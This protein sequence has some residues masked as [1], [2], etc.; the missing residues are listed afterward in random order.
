[1]LISNWGELRAYDAIPAEGPVSD[2]VARE[3]IHGYY[4]CVSYTDAQVGMILDA[5][6]ELD[7]ER[8]TIVILW[9]DH[10][11]NLNEHGLWC[12]HCNFNTSLRT[13]LMLK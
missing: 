11:W 5:L 10:G 7:L 13:T 8:S 3:L 2:S 4:A 9:G 12:K 1:H 6:E